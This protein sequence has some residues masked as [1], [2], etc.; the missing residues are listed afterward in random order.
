MRYAEGEASREKRRLVVYVGASWC[1]PCQRFVDAAQRGELDSLFGEVTLLEFDLD[2][3][4]ER[5]RSAGYGS[6][7]IPLFALAAPDGRASGQ[8][9]DGAIK[10]DGAVAFVIPR[11]AR[12][13]AR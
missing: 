13:L 12:L 7:Y 9:V 5:L 2:R 10:G 1:E 8:Q 3:D 6:E 11:L 4:G